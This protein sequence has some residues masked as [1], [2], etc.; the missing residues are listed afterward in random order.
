MST[1]QI[2]GNGLDSRMFLHILDQ[3]CLH[4]ALSLECVG[5]F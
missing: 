4:S 2:L 1:F 5:T 3:T